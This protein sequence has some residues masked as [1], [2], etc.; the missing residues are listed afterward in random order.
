[1]SRDVYRPKT[2][3][4]GIAKQIAPAVPEYVCDDPTGQYQGEELQ[5]A[6]ERRP[7]PQRI[8]R[9]EDKHDKLDEKVDPIDSRTSRIEGKLDTALAFI[10]DQGKTHR[11]RITTNGKVIVTVVG[12]IV[13]ALTSIAVAVLK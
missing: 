4:P 9:L 7:T 2:P 8:S 6:R 10:T 5:R 12:A 13:T 1:M 11:T 3:P